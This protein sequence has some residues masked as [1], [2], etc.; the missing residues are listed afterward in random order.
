MESFISFPRGAALD[1]VTSVP[2]RCLGLSSAPVNHTKELNLANKEKHLGTSRRE[3]E[4]EEGEKRKKCRDVE[5][6]RRR[7]GV[8]DEGQ[9][10]VEMT[11][12]EGWRERRGGGR[13]G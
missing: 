5:K 9:N 2:N 3:E 7:R 1:V 11:R 4:E 6:G 10:R 8:G 12:K 13:G